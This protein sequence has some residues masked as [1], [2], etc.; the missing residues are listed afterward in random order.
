MKSPFA[1]PAASV[2]AVLTASAV[3][4]GQAPPPGGGAATKGRAADASA[5]KAD[6][7]VF[8]S[9]QSLP[10]PT[11][12]DEL[13]APRIA[14]PT[15]P[16]EPFLLQRHNGPFMVNAYT[17]RGP[18]AMRYAQAL[19]MELRG[20]YH[21]PAYVFSL[22]FQ[23]GHSNIRNVP[24]TAPDAVRDGETVTAP[25]RYRSYDE[26]VVL[27]GD[28]K[29]IDESEKV[30]HQVKKL[31]SDVVDGLPSIYRWRKSK[32]L[33]RATLTT[34]PMAASQHL[35]PRQ[36]AEHAHDK[37][38]GAGGLQQ[39]QAVDPADL[40]AQFKPINKPDPL[41]KQMNGGP[42]SLAKCPGP[43]V[44]E[45]A[46]FSGRVNFDVKDE[47]FTD[48]FL[49]NGSLAAAADQAEALADSLT[50][51]KALDRR[52]KPFVWHDRTSSRVFLG[53]FQ[54]PNDPGI[55][56]LMGAMNA[57]S[58]ELITRGLSPLPLAPAGQ[59]T[60]RDNPADQGVVQ[61]GLVRP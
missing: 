41:L 36:D 5:P 43:Y 1:A 54:G 7:E 33:S 2:V 24:P 13:E 51:V 59:L 19:A 12:L 29:S 17:F 47:R 15:A 10:E 16:I 11:A 40:L 20:K 61:S 26:A 25:E 22:R 35:F 46:T 44:L 23:P 56:A 14:L 30:L 21:L 39:G 28:C 49:K 48:R 52:Y 42:R 50:K 27:V 4:L 60:A 55:P 57:V 53:P 3:V 58:T 38:H 32:G 6:R 31:R 45:V 9:N 34:N 8:K 18:Q 37:T